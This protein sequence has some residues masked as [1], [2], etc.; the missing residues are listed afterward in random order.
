MFGL[1]EVDWRIDSVRAVLLDIGAAI[2]G[3]GRRIDEAVNTEQE[4]YIEAVVDEETAIIEDLLGAAFVVCQTYIS[5]V[6]A[7]VKRWHR[8]A[9]REGVQLTTT[10]GDK[11]DIMRFGSAVAAP[12][13]YTQVA[14]MDAFANCFKHNDEWGFDWTRLPGRSKGT[15]EVVMAAGAQPGSTGNMRTGS[16]TLGNVNYD[17]TCIFADILE[18]WRRNLSQAYVNECRSRSLVAR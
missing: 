6:V 4:D 10:S 7:T 14:V 11:P 1:M 2:R 12:T 17:G 5:S 8:W 3:C 13:R 15:A 18:G 16:T 9:L